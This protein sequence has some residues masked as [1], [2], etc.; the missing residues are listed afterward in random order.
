MLVRDVEEHDLP[1]LFVLLQAKAEFDGAASSL[2]ADPA[3]LREAF[4]S[5]RPMARA[6]V[7]VSEG[8]LAGMVTYYA[9]FSSFIAKP[10][11]WLDDLFVCDSHRSK[12]VGHALMTRLCRVASAHG[13]GCIDWV[14]AAGNDGGKAFYHRLGASIFESVRLARLDENAIQAIAAEDD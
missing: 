4:F 7:A 14:V 1:E 5:P 2:V 6:L 13:C 11:L 9:T 3:A 8:K 12:G 10:C